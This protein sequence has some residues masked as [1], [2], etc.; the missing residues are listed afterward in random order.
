LRLARRGNP[1]RT[2]NSISPRRRPMST[3][4]EPLELANSDA[5]VSFGGQ[6]TR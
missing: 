1:L 2:A 4:I 6:V 5:Q 3:I